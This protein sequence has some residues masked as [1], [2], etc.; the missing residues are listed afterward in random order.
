MPS[1]FN[2]TQAER[3]DL[4]PRKLFDDASADDSTDKPNVP[5]FVPIDDPKCS[6]DQMN[7]AAMDAMLNGSGQVTQQT[8]V[9]VYDALISTAFVPSQVADQKKNKAA[10]I[11]SFLSRVKELDKQLIFPSTQHGQPL[12]EAIKSLMSDI[13]REYKTASHMVFNAL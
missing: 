9:Q 3:T 7:A 4:G 12:R 10:S 11:N 6:A 13:K 1:A 2:T 5:E 8:S